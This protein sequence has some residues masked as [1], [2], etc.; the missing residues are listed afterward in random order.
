VR[1]VGVDA[2]C[3]ANGRGYGRFTRE[4][5]RAM[6]TAPGWTFVYFADPASAALVDVTSPNV[7]VVE[8]PQSVAPTQAAA[9]GGHSTCS[10]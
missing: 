3:W 2:T 7:R 10:V 1:T 6:S 5:L 4:L 9:A 8:V